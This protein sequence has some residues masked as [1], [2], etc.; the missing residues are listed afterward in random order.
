MITTGAMRPP[1]L[2]TRGNCPTQQIKMGGRLARG[3]RPSSSG[4]KPHAHITVGEE[5]STDIELYYEDHGRGEPVVLIHGYPLSGASWEKQVP[6]LLEAGHRVITYDR[7]G[8]GK[9]SQP[10]SGYD[11]DTFAADLNELL[12]HLDLRDA[13]LVGLLDGQRR[14]GPLPGH[15]TARTR[16]ARRCSCRR[17]RR[18]CSRPA[19]TPRA[20]TAACSTGSSRGHRR[21]PAR[22]DPGSWTT[23]TTWTCWAESWSARR[24]GRPAGTSPRRLSQG[25]RGLRRR[26]GLTDFREDLPKIDVPTLVVHGDDDRILPLATTAS[27]SARPDQGHASSSSIE[28]GPHGIAWT[29]ADQVNR[30]LLDFLRT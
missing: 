24:P 16:V 1:E 10:T 12:D 28:G 26:P 20:W 30:A 21:R 2:A 8:F 29:H 22:P 9:S 15:A 4:R 14:G 13:T 5:N 25:A 6:A 3:R 23:S 18:T 11:Y 7:R 27:A 17:S 19:T